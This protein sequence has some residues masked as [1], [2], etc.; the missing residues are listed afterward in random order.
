MS[1]TEIRAGIAE[2][3]STIPGL[4]ATALVLDNVNPP[5]AVVEPV[6]INY[7]AVMGRGLDEYNFK[8][9]VIVGRASERSAQNLIDTYCTGSGPASVKGA[10]ESDRT[11]GGKVNDLRVTRLSSYGSFTIADVNYLAADFAVVVYA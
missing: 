10:I 8:V 11:L 1:I 4:R 2:N 6:G 3:L 7:D 5:V 9:T